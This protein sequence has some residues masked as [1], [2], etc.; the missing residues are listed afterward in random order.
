MNVAKRAAGLKAEID[1]LRAAR[2]RANAV[3]AEGELSRQN[4]IRS[5]ANVLRL[6]AEREAELLDLETNRA[7]VRQ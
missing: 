7:P 6:L 5:R 3:L 2:D 4:L 1:L